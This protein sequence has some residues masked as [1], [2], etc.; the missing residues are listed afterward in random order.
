MEIFG[1]AI[2]AS[3]RETL[4]KPAECRKAEEAWLIYVHLIPACMLPQDFNEFRSC[5]QES[6]KL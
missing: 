5:A 2:K 4:I 1:L 3:H 6:L